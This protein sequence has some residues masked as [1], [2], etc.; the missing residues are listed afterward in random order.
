MQLQR[1]L[2]CS[3]VT[4]EGS[5]VLLYSCRSWQVL[6]TTSSSLPSDLGEVPAFLPPALPFLSL[7]GSSMLFPT[8]YIDLDD[9]RLIQAVIRCQELVWDFA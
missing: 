8:S 9:L 6:A 3:S 7:C 5:R 2:E 4:P 1:T